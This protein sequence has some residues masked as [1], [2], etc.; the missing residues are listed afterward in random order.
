MIEPGAVG[1][2]A[3]S[4][5]RRQSQIARARNAAPK[6]RS[7]VDSSRRAL[8]N[9]ASA[10]RTLPPFRYSPKATRATQAIA[11]FRL[12][13]TAALDAIEERNLR[14]LLVYF[15]NPRYTASTN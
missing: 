1:H 15:F 10:P 6:A 4:V 2:A 7:V 11:I 9:T 5:A 3:I 12:S 14:A 13:F 8:D